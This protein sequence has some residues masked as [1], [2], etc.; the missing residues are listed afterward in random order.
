MHLSRHIAAYVTQR[1]IVQV[2]VLA[3]HQTWGRPQQARASK[4]GA[5]GWLRGGRDEKRAGMAAATL[6]ATAAGAV[7]GVAAAA[8]TTVTTTQQYGPA[9]S[10]DVLFPA[11]ASA[12]EL[13]SISAGSVYTGEAA[14]LTIEAIASDNS[15]LPLFDNTDV[16]PYF[17]NEALASITNNSFSSF[18]AQDIVGL[19]FSWSNGFFSPTAELPVGTEFVFVAVPEPAVG[20]MLACSL[21][22]VCFGHRIKRLVSARAPR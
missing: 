15:I 12:T 19:R 22:V 20:V 6:L 7:P 4:S 11:V 9:A 3:E 21:A 16:Q 14:Q 1:A 8:V 2:S 5:D 18:S 17:S 10:F 13:T